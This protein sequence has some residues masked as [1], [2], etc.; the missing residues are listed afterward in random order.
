MSE[1]PSALV[2]AIHEACGNLVPPPPVPA[3]PSY[4]APDPE[5]LLRLFEEVRADVERAMDARNVPGYAY[6][7][8]PHLDTLCGYVA[9][10]W[11]RL[12][13]QET[14]DGALYII[15]KLAYD[16]GAQLLAYQF[17]NKALVM[18]HNMQRSLDVADLEVA[19]MTRT[20]IGQQHVTDEEAVEQ[21]GGGT[22][23]AGAGAGSADGAAW[24]EPAGADPAGE[25]L[26]AAVAS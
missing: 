22:L 24:G 2:R 4:A 15:N 10:N 23:P 21:S 19:L 1:D 13:E 26:E 9:D 18:T 6:I 14:F 5:A 3:L 25:P 16:P 17:F 8:A 20:G 11:G 12:G 7:F